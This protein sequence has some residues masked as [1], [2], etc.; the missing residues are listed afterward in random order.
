LEKVLKG[1]KPEFCL[2][3]SSLSSVLGG[4]GHAA[5]SAANIFMD[6]FVHLHN[7]TGKTH[8]ISVNWDTWHT[9][10]EKETSSP[11]S[12]V[13]K[14]VVEMA[15]TGEEGAAAFQRILSRIE[16]GQVAVSTHDLQTR[17]NRWITFENREAEKDANK[18][19]AGTLQP[20]PDL[21]SP[22][23]PPE[24]QLE[25]LIADIWQKLLGVEKIGIY[26]NFFDLGATSL[27]IIQVNKKLMQKLERNIP[28]D[29][30][31]EYPSIASLAKYL[32]GSEEDGEISN[33]KLAK[34]AK[35]M[36]DTF[37]KFKGMKNDTHKK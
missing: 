12:P 21:S 9:G 28:V 18:K 32:S 7:R 20:R 2:L 33:K 37:R 13:G 24:S 6:H 31:F 4:L 1:T 23:T 35:R 36:D 16:A 30:M 22:F 26:D 27:D 29:M 10:K 3:M 8:W 34:S 17:I 5:Y 11:A 25:R 19:E 14:T 15:M